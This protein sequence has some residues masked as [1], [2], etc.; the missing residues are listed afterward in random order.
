M[1]D[2]AIIASTIANREPLLKRSV[3]TWNNSINAAGL[4]GVICIYSEADS[5]IDY[6]FSGGFWE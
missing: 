4:N 5:P 1:H 3:Q 6:G 2:V